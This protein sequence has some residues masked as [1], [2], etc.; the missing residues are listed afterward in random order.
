MCVEKE[1][2]VMDGAKLAL[3]WAARLRCGGSHYCAWDR[4]HWV[5]FLLF[6]VSGRG[7]AGN[8]YFLVVVTL[9]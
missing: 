6:V 2:W 1:G 9:G 3:T 5:V 4:S 8:G 7:E